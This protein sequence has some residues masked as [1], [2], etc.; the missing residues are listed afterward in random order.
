MSGNDWRVSLHSVESF[1]K[2]SGKIKPFS[3]EPVDNITAPVEPALGNVV[4][5]VNRITGHDT[6]IVVKSVNMHRGNVST[7]RYVEVVVLLKDGA[8]V[9]PELDSEL[10][11]KYKFYDVIP[12]SPKVEVAPFHKIRRELR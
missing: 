9:P 3:Y 8:T 1:Y 6:L 7:F 10:V 12:W 2:W 5:K 4:G 11:R